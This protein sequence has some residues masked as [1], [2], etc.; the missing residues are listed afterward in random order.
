MEKK[1]PTNST[2]LEVQWKWECRVLQNISE[3]KKT[4]PNE[5]INKDILSVFDNFEIFFILTFLKLV[6]VIQWI[7]SFNKVGLFF[8]Q[9]TI[10]KL[11]MHLTISGI[12]ISVKYGNSKAKGIFILE[13]DHKDKES[14]V[15]TGRLERCVITGS[16]LN[17]ESSSPK[18]PVGTL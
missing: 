6:W 4:I 12:L 15:L 18:A 14:G 3:Q 9:K 17:L 1:I 10:K 2:K 13:S 5:D 11:M 7:C 16:E 8:F